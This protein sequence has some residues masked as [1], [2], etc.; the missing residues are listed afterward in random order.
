MPTGPTTAAQSA[1]Q[2]CRRFFAVLNPQLLKIPFA[3]P[4]NAYHEKHKIRKL[5]L[6]KIRLRNVLKRASERWCPSAYVSTS[7]NYGAGMHEK[8]FPVLALSLHELTAWRAP[9]A[10]RGTG[11]RRGGREIQRTER[12]RTVVTGGSCKGTAEANCAEMQRRVQNKTANLSPGLIRSKRLCIYALMFSHAHEQPDGGGRER[13]IISAHIDYTVNVAIIRCRKLELQL[14][15]KISI[16]ETSIFLI[17]PDAM[18]ISARPYF[19]C[20]SCVLLYGVR[21]SQT[22]HRRRSAVDAA[23][24]PLV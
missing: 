22:K 8:T 5:D 6:R 17:V 24:A 7:F 23:V 4:Q 15:V 19:K 16:C 20:T 10:A 3:V 9:G 13:E 18:R 12:D 14:K 21:Q 11:K 2:R 1:Q